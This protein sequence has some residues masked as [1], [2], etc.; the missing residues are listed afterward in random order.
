MTER[1]PDPIKTWVEQ[2][3]PGKQTIMTVEK[4]K[5][6]TST[7]LYKIVTNSDRYVLR[8]YNNK[9]WLSE[10]P[11][12][13]IHEAVSLKTAAANHFGARSPQLINVDETGKHAGLP[14][15]LMQF[16]PGEVVLK[17]DDLDAWLKELAKVLA[18]IHRIDAD[19]FKW[20]FRRYTNPNELKVPDWTE[21]PVLWEKGRQIVQSREPR[22]KETFIHRDYHPVNVLWTGGKISSVVDWV[23]ACRGPAGIDVG[24]CRNNLV[25]LFGVDAADTFL[26]YYKTFASGTFSYDPY[27]DL[28]AYFDFVYPGP[29]EV[30]EGWKDF[31]WHDLSDA[32]ITERLETY[33]VSLIKKCT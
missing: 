27:W 7:T 30:Y 32:I 18:G 17:P 23:N 9:S 16:V 11:D 6:A 26:N 29:P 15:I 10:E 21:H 25:C 24:H 28:V 3:L 4:L 14:M 2:S 12:L 8:L 20:T 22:Y 13:A 5:G 33:F 31:G 1:L 19:H